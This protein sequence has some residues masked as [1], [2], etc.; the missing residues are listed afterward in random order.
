MALYNNR[1]A[2]YFKEGN[3]DK[4]MQDITSILAFDPVH[5][6]ARNRRAKIYEEQV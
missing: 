1:S 6:K 5:M 4:A 3:I 2:M